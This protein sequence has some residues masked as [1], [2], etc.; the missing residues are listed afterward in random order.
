M[1]GRTT[2][3]LAFVLSILF[4]ASCG[5]K[6]TSN[7]R[8]FVSAGSADSSAPSVKTEIST[9]EYDAAVTEQL[10]AIDNETADNEP[11]VW[12]NFDGAII[13]KGTQK[14]QSNLLC[15]NYATIP[16]SRFSNEDKNQI[17][18]K[19]QDFLSKTEANIKV[20]ATKP[21]A[22][23]YRLTQIHLGGTFNDL[24]CKLDEKIN[25]IIP[26]D[27]LNAKL[28]HTGFIFTKNLNDL[29][30]ISEE[31]IASIGKSVGVDPAS[32]ESVLQD[33]LNSI[34]GKLTN[35][36]DALLGTV[37]KDSITDSFDNLP[38]KYNSLRGLDV[39]LALSEELAKLKGNQILDISA[40][41]GELRDT[42]PGKVATPE[43]DRIITILLRGQNQ[44]EETKEKKEDGFGDL[45]K[46][47]LKEI[48]VKKAG[49][50]LSLTGS[51]YSLP[52]LSRLL[53][54]N[55]ITDYTS[56]YQ[57]IQLYSEVIKTHFTGATRDALLSLVKVAHAQAYQQN[58]RI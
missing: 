40:M 52:N 23:I 22:S 46:D 42:L 30:K 21:I 37:P 54:V 12:L 9:A 45:F 47:I 20:V 31:I 24:G 4:I 36:V 25:S 32:A 5:E 7:N 18:K 44:D 58:I 2:K 38:V 11:T 27:R 57:S 6:K 50:A 1:E 8:T 48:I 51:I 43:L 55:H 14:G 34:F 41:Q 19:V 49:D 35:K 29:D 28:T 3:T 33:K 53:Q 16:S 10:N 15:K 17:I 56:L 39:I 26:F 13:E